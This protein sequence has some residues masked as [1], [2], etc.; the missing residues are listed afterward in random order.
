MLVEL[1]SVTADGQ[2]ADGSGSVQ[3]SLLFLKAGPAGGLR[4]S[5]NTTADGPHRQAAQDDSSTPRSPTLTL[6]GL[7]L[8]FLLALLLKRQAMELPGVFGMRT[9]LGGPLRV[10]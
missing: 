5:N 4:P 2:S 1:C 6:A 7:A 10:T 3:P 9:S 8:P